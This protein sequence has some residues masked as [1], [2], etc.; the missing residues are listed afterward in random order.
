MQPDGSGSYYS[1]EDAIAAWPRFIATGLRLGSPAVANAD[2]SDNDWLGQFMSQASANNYR[3]DFIW[4]HKYLYMQN[5]DV[6]SG[7]QELQQYLELIHNKFQLPIWLT[8][9]AMINFYPD[10]GGSIIY[11]SAETEVQFLQAAATMMDSLG[12]V[13]RYAWYS[14]P[15]D[16][17]QSTSYLYNADGSPTLVGQAFSSLPQS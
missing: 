10:N 11:P 9:F 7:V 14:L 17:P 3:V 5:F 15:Q 12:F 13:E 8:E 6:A 1:V 4:L 16:T 2:G